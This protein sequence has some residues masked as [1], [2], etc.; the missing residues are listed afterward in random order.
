M[1]DKYLNGQINIE[2]LVLFYDKNNYSKKEIKEGGIVYTPF[3][4]AK[5]IVEI[6]KPLPNET[7]WEPSVG[8]GIFIFALLDYMKNK[9]DNLKKYFLDRVYGSDIKERNISE[10]KLIA[11]A[12]FKKEGIDISLDEIVNFKVENSLLN[13]SKFDIV[14]GNPPYVKFQNLNNIQRKFLQDNFISCSKGN[15]DLY[16]AFIEKAFNNGRRSSFITANSWM[17]NQSAYNLRKIIKDNLSFVVDFKHK[18]IFETADT[19][20]SIFLLNK[21]S[22]TLKYTED[23]DKESIE[24]DKNK[25]DD[26]RWS[27]GTSLNIKIPIVKFHTP[28]ATLQ[29]KSFIN[30]GF[31]NKDFVPFYKLSKIKSREEFYSLGDR[32]LF[33][34]HYPEYTLKNEKDFETETLQYLLKKKDNLLKRDGGKALH[35][36]RWYAY[37]RKQGLNCYKEDTYFLVVPGII[38]LDYEFF[39]VYSKKIKKPFLFSSGFLI[40]VESKYKVS[41]A[42]FFNSSEFKEFL[43]SNGKV[44]KGKKPYYSL[45][46]K[47][48]KLIFKN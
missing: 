42:N 38:S 18:M 46:M 31:D 5:Y 10:F 19:Y 39:T 2:E 21:K 28:I 16:Y 6:L 29:D 4:I 34:Y 8:H 1:I 24:F 25:L 45:T 35:Y 30:V 9:T 13:N 12:Y 17:Y 33:P 26:K 20:T 44:W 32:I 15:I 40:E 11:Q 23:L 36:I 47:Q 22:K 14:F 7:I 27:F 37:G 3:Y 48:L 41:I 43:V